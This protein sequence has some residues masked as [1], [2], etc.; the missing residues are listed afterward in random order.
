MAVEDRDKE[1]TAFSTPAGHFEFN[2][3]PFRLT[4]A[5]AT[6][7]RLMEYVLAGLAGEE[8]LIYLDDVIIF[9]SSFK[10]HL[11]RLTKVFQALQKVGLQL[12][13]TKCQFAHREVK[14]LGHIFFEQG[15]KPDPD[16]LKAVSDYISC[17]QEYH[18]TE[19][20]PRPE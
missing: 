8:C 7:Q 13:P 12:K 5:P 9:S 14:Y 16:K 11:L 15:I 19:T 2:V 20:V 4:N 17:S 10:D 1:K 18:R 3:M 6:F